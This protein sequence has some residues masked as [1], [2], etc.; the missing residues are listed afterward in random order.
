MVNLLSRGKT[1]FKGNSLLT[2]DFSLPFAF[3]DK[4]T[5]VILYPAPET[6]PHWLY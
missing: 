6:A 5:V 3:I 2:G 1:Q 4:I